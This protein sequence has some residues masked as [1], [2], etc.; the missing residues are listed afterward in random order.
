MTIAHLG[1]KMWS[2]QHRGG[3]VLVGF[4]F[5]YVFS[6]LSN[7]HFLCCLLFVDVRLDV[8]SSVLS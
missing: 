5:S 8:V 4:S 1:L 3:A 7:G 6:I 2:V